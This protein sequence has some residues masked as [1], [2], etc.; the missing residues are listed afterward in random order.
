MKI[1]AGSRIYSLFVLVCGYDSCEFNSA[2]VNAGHYICCKPSPHYWSGHTHIEAFTVHVCLLVA[3]C[4]YRKL[5][6]K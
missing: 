6:I 5:Q 4:R 2:T 3:C 1:T